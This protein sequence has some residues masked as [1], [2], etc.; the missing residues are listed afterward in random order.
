MLLQNPAPGACLRYLDLTN[1]CSLGATP[2]ASAASTANVD[3]AVASGVPDFGIQSGQPTDQ[4]GDCLGINNK[5][6]PC[7]CL[8]DCREF[9]QKV[10]AAVAASNSEGAPVNFPLNNSSA[11]KKARIQ[12]SMTVLNNF[13]RLGEGCPLWSTTFQA[14]LDSV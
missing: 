6:I 1:I 9:I 2:T 7:D 3:P 5:H 10:A 11:S 13:N 12:T 8:P 14:Q 4:P